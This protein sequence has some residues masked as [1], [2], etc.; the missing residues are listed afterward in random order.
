MATTLFT[1]NIKGPPPGTATT[2]AEQWI[3]LGLIPST[4]DI[5]IGNAQ[6][7]SPDKAITFELRTNNLTTSTGTLVN[8]TLLDSCAVT[9]RSGTLLRDLYKNGTLHIKTVKSTGIE[10]WWLR[11]TSKSSTAGGYLF[12]I[13]YTLE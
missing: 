3:D 12:S 8:T 5:W 13:N 2:A 9:V 7:A 11:L 10:H 1:T 4:F 6:Y